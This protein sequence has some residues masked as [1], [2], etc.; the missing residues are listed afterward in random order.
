MLVFLKICPRCSSHSTTF[1]RCTHPNPRLQWLSSYVSNP[2]LSSKLQIHLFNSLIRFSVICLK[3]ISNST[4]NPEP[5]PLFWPHKLGP[6]PVFPIWRIASLPTKMHEARNLRTHDI[7]FS[8]TPYI[9]SITTACQFYLLMPLVSSTENNS[10]ATTLVQVSNVSLL[11]HF[12]G[13]PIGPL[14]SNFALPPHCS[15]T[16][17]SEWSLYTQTRHFTTQLKT[18]NGFP[19]S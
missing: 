8:F 18:L 3:G 11:F 12:R 4:T 14:P 19:L 5:G 2:D 7:S 6:H 10:N 9:Q 17:K 1:P 15:S 13:L 16:L